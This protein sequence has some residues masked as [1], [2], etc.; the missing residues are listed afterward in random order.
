MVLRFYENRIVVLGGAGDP[1]RSEKLP[2]ILTRGVGV[3]REGENVYVPGLLMGLAISINNE[4][5]NRDG[6]INPRI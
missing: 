2:S 4:A 1:N 5:P 3:G 6:D